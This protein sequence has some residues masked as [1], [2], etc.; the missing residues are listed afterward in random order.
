VATLLR[1]VFEQP[2]TDAVHAQMRHV[3]EALEAKFPKAAEHLDAAQHDVLA[4]A[5]FPREIWRQIWS[6]CEDGR[7][8]LPRPGLARG[9]TGTRA[10]GLIC[11]SR[12]G[13]GRFLFRLRCRVP[14]GASPLTAPSQF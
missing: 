4:F 5:A 9:P 8:P 11:R 3:L 7:A 10:Y 2:D 13:S 14:I 1:T 6:N 12:P